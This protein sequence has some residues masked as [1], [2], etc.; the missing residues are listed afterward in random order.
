M[1]PDG[2]PIDVIFMDAMMTN[3]H[4]PEATIAIRDLGYRGCIVAVTGNTL[5]EDVNHFLSCGA[6]VFLSKPLQLSQL[7]KVMNGS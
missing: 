7:M 5:K 6:D 4:G 3:M 2:M 1:Q